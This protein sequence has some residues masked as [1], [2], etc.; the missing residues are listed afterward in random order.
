[1][2]NRIRKWLI[3][4]VVIKQAEKK[5]SNHVS[6]CFSICV[7][8]TIN[9]FPNCGM[10]SDCCF[11]N[12]LCWICSYYNYYGVFLLDIRLMAL[13]LDICNGLVDWA[14]LGTHLSLHLCIK[15]GMF[16]FEFFLI[17]RS[18]CSYSNTSDYVSFISVHLK[19]KET[20]S[21]NNV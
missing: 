18:R 11:I 5:S 14:I 20:V 12:S 17:P 16:R 21:K 1:M 13:V 4:T 15:S 3:I 10:Y 9:N 7:I 8:W 2:R 19:S 6:F